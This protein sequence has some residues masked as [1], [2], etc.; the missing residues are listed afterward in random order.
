VNA[1]AAN[2]LKNLEVVTTL[3]GQLSLFCENR[4][5]QLSHSF[6]RT[7]KVLI[8]NFYKMILITFK[9]FRFLENKIPSGF[10]RWFSQAGFQIF[11]NP[12]F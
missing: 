4:W 2:F 1:M 3:V 9:G 11:K 12:I 6:K 7:F 8:N 5:F 10:Q